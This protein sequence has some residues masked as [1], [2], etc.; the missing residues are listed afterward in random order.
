MRG[1]VPG[2]SA[3]WLRVGQPDLP[4]GKVSSTEAE[5]QEISTRQRLIL[6]AVVVVIILVVLAMFG[7]IRRNASVVY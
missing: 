4:S 6:R 3:R 5:M 1:A 7:L 2:V